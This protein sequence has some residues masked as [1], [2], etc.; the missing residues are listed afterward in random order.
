MTV[1]SPD[2]LEPDALELVCP[3]PKYA[4]ENRTDFFLAQA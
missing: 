4:A 2:A 3:T 1:D